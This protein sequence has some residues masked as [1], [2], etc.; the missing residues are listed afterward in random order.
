[1][2]DANNLLADKVI[3]CTGGAGTICS[4][5]VRAMVTLG[6]NAFIVGRNASKTESMAQSLSSSRPGSRVIGLGNVD[7]RSVESLQSAV[8]KCIQEF[9]RIDFCIAGA[10]GNFLA[11][12]SQLSANAFKTVIDIDLLGSFNTAKVC[13]PHLVSAAREHP[14]GKSRSPSGRIIFVSATMHYTGN[15]LQT[16]AVA[17]KAGVDAL[18]AQIC[19][20]YGPLGLT[21]NVIAPGPIAGTE[22]LDRLSK[23][24]VGD[25]G[26]A[27][28]FKNVPSGR[29][30]S[31]KDIADATVYL[32]SDAANY[33]NGEVL[34]VDGGAWRTGRG[35]GSDFDYP[36]FLLQGRVVD[37]VAGMKKEKKKEGSGAKL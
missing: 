15:A 11:P 14:T 25:G 32:F 20:E 29:A 24:R 31:V 12:I 2:H 19:I 18:S 28:A 7:V 34:V 22:G 26:G 30:G 6:A 37:G 33:V 1:M 9:G 16:H 3:F 36:E 8:D 10:A 23:K 17:A 13:L 4:V 35:P 21:S 5:Q 27:N